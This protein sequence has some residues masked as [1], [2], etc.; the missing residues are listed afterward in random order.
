MYC[1]PRWEYNLVPRLI[2]SFHMR[3]RA[4]VERVS[5]T[6]SDINSTSDTAAQSDRVVVNGWCYGWDTWF[7]MQ[8]FFLTNI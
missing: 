6:I 5:H 2:A 7:H 8:V 1:K 3:E 4:L